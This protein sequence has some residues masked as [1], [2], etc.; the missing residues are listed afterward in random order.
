MATAADQE[1]HPR[2]NAEE[3]QIHTGEEGRYM[4]YVAITQQIPKTVGDRLMMRTP[5]GGNQDP[6]DGRHDCY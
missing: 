4:P 2:G 5:V 6:N 3:R 1:G